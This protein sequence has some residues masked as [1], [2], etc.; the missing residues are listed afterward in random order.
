VRIMW[1]TIPHCRRL[2][3]GSIRVAAA[4]GAART[5]TA[6]AAPAFATSSSSRRQPSLLSPNA[7]ESESRVVDNG[8]TGSIR[9]SSSNSGAPRQ[10]QQRR[11]AKLAAVI[12]EGHHALQSGSARLQDSLLLSTTPRTATAALVSRRSNAPTV[13]ADPSNSLPSIGSSDDGTDPESGPIPD[14]ASASL[15]WSSSSLNA[16]MLDDETQR[17]MTVEQ[18]AEGHRL[19]EAASNALE[20]MCR[21][22]YAS[23][24]TGGLVLAGSPI[25][26]L[27]VHVHKNLRSAVMYW[28]LPLPIVWDDTM[29][30]DVK[31]EMVQWFDAQLQTD[32]TPQRRALQE[33]TRRVAATL[34]SYR[35]PRIIWKPAPP[36][37]MLAFEAY[38]QNDAGG[39]N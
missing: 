15:P 7:N 21:R 27:D 5:R 4:A 18:I 30:D 1:R 2:S 13:H 11:N 14:D 6:A 17:H 22:T 31:H 29:S 16:G 20:A 28:T 8:G 24:G 37:M 12:R 23:D 3:A 25:V 19:M 39:G 34:R 26:L 38:Q 10:Q 9:N 32:G 33:L 35:V 36:D